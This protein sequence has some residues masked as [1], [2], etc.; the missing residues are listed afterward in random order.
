MAMHDKYARIC[1]NTAGWRRP[2]GDA[3]GAETGSYVARNG[4]GHEEW[5][6]NFEWTI[7]GFR[8]GFLQPIGK[9]YEKYRGQS[10]SILLYTLTPQT[11]T[12]LV[13]QISDVYVPEPDELTEALE[14]S[15]KKGWLDS[16]R[17]DV[18]RVKGKLEILE[19]P[20]PRTIANVRFRPRDVEIFDPRR[21]VTGEHKIA[22]IRRYQPFDWNKEDYPGTEMRL[23]HIKKKDPRRS[24]KKMTRAA[25]E[26]V[27]VDPG[28]NR[29]Q[30]RLYKHLCRIYGTG[31]VHYEKDFVDLTV[32]EPGGNVVFF[33]I[34]TEMT[35]KR[36]I[37]QAMGQLLEYAHYGG[38]SRAGRLVVVGDAEP[39]EDD[40][41]YLVSLRRKYNLP[42]Y[43]SRFLWESGR[44]AEEI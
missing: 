20:E 31:K 13:G 5:I 15:K 17:A 8:Y 43:Y 14:I 4:F 16:M 44:L 12:L 1:W 6:F 29:L 27:E 35:A 26:G 40:R 11:K 3:A 36:C 25:Q 37:R 41:A 10:C 2:T 18:E 23:P 32:E 9:Y 34:K 7:R 19:D 24:E 42:I 39:T 33:E 22:Q 28:H 21:L 30:N 38:N